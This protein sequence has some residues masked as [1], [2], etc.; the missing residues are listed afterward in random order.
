MKHNLKFY[1]KN[2]LTANE[3]KFA[4]SSFD[5]VG[6]ILIFSEFSKELAKKEKIIG[7]TILENYPHIK[8]VLKKIN[9][10][11]GKFR[12]P[13]LKVIAGENR[14]ETI[15]KENNVF[16]KLDAEKVYFSPRMS[17]ERKRIAGLVKP[18]ES[19]LVMFNGCAPYSLVIAKNTKCREVY[20]IEINP[21]ANEYA[22]ENIKKNKLENKIRLFL[23]DV[24]KVMPR[25]NKKFDRILMP[26][27]KG[28]ENFLDLALRCIKKNGIVHFYD[29]LH[30]DEF[31]KAGEKVKSACLK[32]KR[33][34][35][36]LK[37]IKCGQ[38]SPRFYRVCVDFV[39][40]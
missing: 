15:C 22:L 33:K 31:H 20:G 11:A 19:V 26:L 28:G 1:L 25:L 13:K 2:R 40:D 39:V 8:T 9:K 24:R 6:D 5:V 10:Y 18:N 32:S 36:I 35:R 37:T 7:N 30:E 38:Y 17:S 3:L 4:P 29:F 21:I 16:I 34:F 27:P 14:K 12:T 23:G